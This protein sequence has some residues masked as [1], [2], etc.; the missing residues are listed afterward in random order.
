[1]AS[2]ISWV[3]PAKAPETSPTVRARGPALESGPPHRAAPLSF[4]PPRPPIMAATH[5]PTGATSRGLASW[6][7]REKR[8]CGR[9]EWDKR[10]FFSKPTSLYSPI[11]RSFRTRLFAFR[12]LSLTWRAFSSL[13][14]VH[15]RWRLIHP[16]PSLG[17]SLILRPLHLMPW[18]PSR[19]PFQ[20]PGLLRAWSRDSDLPELQHLL[21]CVVVFSDHVFIPQ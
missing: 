1:M 7:R 11:Y 13:P 19:Y 20:P 4:L 5:A 10:T 6:T 17:F 8:A 16:F 15:P 9:S 14:S 18:S 21:G 3:A 12:S 2:A